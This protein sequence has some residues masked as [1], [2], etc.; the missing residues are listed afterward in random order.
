[1][2]TIG[3]AAVFGKEQEIGMIQKG[4]KADMILIDEGKPHMQP[5]LLGND[6]LQN[7]IQKNVR[8]ENVTSAIVFNATGGD[9]TDVFVNGKRL[10]KD[11]VLTT[12]DVPALCAKVRQ[13]IEKI[14][15]KL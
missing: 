2:A 1:M 9:I 5:L 15:E 3:G 10:V 8:H 7:V 11:G 13:T 14:A 12:V 6:V 4:M